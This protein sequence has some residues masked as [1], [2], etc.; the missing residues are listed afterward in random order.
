ME[1]GATAG[2]GGVVGR[3]WLPVRWGSGRFWAYVG[4]VLGGSVSLAANYAHTYVPPAG[5]SQSWS[6]PAGAV[7]TALCWPALLFVA[8]EILVRTEWPGQSRWFV[9]RYLGLLP[10]AGVAAFVSYRHL[11]GLLAFYGEDTLTS[12]IGPLA[13]DGL[14][15]MATGALLAGSSQVKKSRSGGVRAGVPGP[16]QVARKQAAKRA[17]VLSRPGDDLAVLAGE[18]AGEL[19][20]QGVTVS[21]RRLTSE[22]RARGHSI[23]NSRA[24]VLLRSLDGGQG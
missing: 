5:A 24:G 18:V 4:V 3:R 13:I 20:R 12:T 16:Q 6:P 10:V 2:V 17:P 1:R 15:I 9:A 21:R 14:M 19:R 23:S 8:V 22:L 7:V 11:S